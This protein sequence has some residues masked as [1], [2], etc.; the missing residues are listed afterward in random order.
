MAVALTKSASKTVYRCA[1]CGHVQSKWAGQCAGC[2]AWNTLTE[3]IEARAPLRSTGYAGSADVTRVMPLAEVQA[4]PFARIVTGSGELDRVLGGGLVAGSAVLLG[5]DPGIGKSTLLL[6]T[7]AR[8]SSRVKTLY[9]TGEESAQQVGL[10]ARRLEL[11]SQTVHILP[12]VELD[13]ILRAT[14]AFGPGVLVLDS[15]QT[16]YSPTLQSAP[17]SVGQVRECAAQLV[18]YAKQTGTAVILVGHVTKD[19]AIAGPRVLEHMVDTVLYFEGDGSGR[20]R[21]IRAMKNRYGAANEL[22]IFAMTEAGLKEVR[23]PSAIFLSRSDHDAP[24]SVVTVLREGSRQL[25]VEV[26]ALADTSQGGNPRRIAVGLDLNRMALL[27]AV[28]HR[29]GGA[30]LH[31]ADV[32]VNVVGGLR[33]SE[34]AGDLAVALAIQSSARGRALPRDWVV[35]GELGLTGELRPVSGGTERLREVAKHGFKHAVIP[36]ANA[37]KEAVPGLEIVALQR[38]EDAFGLW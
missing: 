28:L 3:S 15:I 20:Y 14:R 19:G 22:G 7:L 29:A 17:G 8:M 30:A 33:L 26:Q 31:G 11:D 24:G 35:F 5:G 25:L 13:T 18:A 27:L 6:Q 2:L 23:N 37:P 1:D 10:R 9:V 32:F 4:E 12:A 38:L 16:M 34:P 36:A 21:M